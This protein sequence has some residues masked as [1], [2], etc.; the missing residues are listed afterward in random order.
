MHND[1]DRQNANTTSSAILPENNIFARSTRQVWNYC[2]EIKILITSSFQ[3]S[4]TRENA[5]IAVND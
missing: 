4:N 2:N 3:Q 1:A 5:R